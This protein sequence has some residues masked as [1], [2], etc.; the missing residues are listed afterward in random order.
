MISID[1]PLAHLLKI[2]RA[3]EPELVDP[4]LGAYLGISIEIELDLGLWKNNRSLISALGHQSWVL[5]T[6]HALFAHHVMPKLGDHRDERDQSGHFIGPDPMVDR[7]VPCKD[8]GWIHSPIEMKISIEYSRDELVDIV[9]GDF[10]INHDRSCCA[11]HRA[12]IQKIEPES[13]CELLRDR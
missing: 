4:A 7:F 12:G 9:F 10:V 8:R 1:D 5:S 3:F 11:I 2:D 6:D 13:M